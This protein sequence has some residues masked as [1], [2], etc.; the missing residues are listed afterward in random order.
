MFKTEQGQVFKKYIPVLTIVGKS[1][2]GK[3][4]LLEKLIP[5]LKHRGFRIA[6]VKHHTHPGFEIDHPGKDT[7]RHAQA[8]SDYVILASPDKIAWIRRL[9]KELSLD[10]ITETVSGVDLVLTEGY[11]SAGKTALE[12]VRKERGLD[13]ICSPDQLL[14]IAT[15][16]RLEVDAPQFDLNDSSSIADFI[17]K[18]VNS[19]ENK[20]F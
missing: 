9:D 17:E 14:L 5:E 16:T 20:D 10:E 3:T 8:G 7:W 18:W 1:K 6:T 13:I 15:D 2:S 12:V 4:T 11:K 19:L